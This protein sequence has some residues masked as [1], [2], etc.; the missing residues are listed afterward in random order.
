[1]GQ[2]RFVRRA[3]APYGPQ[4]GV[5]HSRRCG[6]TASPL[7]RRARAPALSRPLPRSRPAPPPSAAVPFAHPAGA[8]GTADAAAQYSEYIDTRLRIL[9]ES[10]DALGAI[11]AACPNA[12]CLTS[13][14]AFAPIYRVLPPALQPALLNFTLGPHADAAFARWADGAWAAGRAGW[15]AGAGAR[16]EAGADAGST[17]AAP[18]RAHR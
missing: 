6:A 1:M 13:L 7:Q 2:L 18:T 5:P 17:G 8:A 9:T 15:Q 12:T 14:A 3:G 10:Q 16:A 11:E 4:P